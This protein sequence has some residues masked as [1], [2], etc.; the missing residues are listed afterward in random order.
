MGSPPARRVRLVL[1]VVR[2]HNTI[3]S[4]WCAVRV[5]TQSEWGRAIRN[6]TTATFSFLRKFLLATLRTNVQLHTNVWPRDI[7]SGTHS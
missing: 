4:A 2:V 3:V 5:T 1:P 7:T 6:L